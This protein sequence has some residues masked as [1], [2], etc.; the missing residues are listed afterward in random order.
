MDFGSILLKKQRLLLISMIKLGL[1]YLTMIFLKNL[2]L[3][4]SDI[5]VPNILLT[6]S[7]QWLSQIVG[8]ASL[9]DDL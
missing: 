5:G 6:S 7:K 8:V 9:S 2:M 1:K 4:K 3:K